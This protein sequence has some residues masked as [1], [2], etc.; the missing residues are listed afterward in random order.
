MLKKK[1]RLRSD[2][3]DGSL[4]YST[5]SAKKESTL[6]RCLEAGEDVI[7]FC[8]VRRFLIRFTLLPP[9]SD[10]ACDLLDSHLSGGKEEKAL[11]G[12]IFCTDETIDYV[13]P[14]AIR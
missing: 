4:F 7:D 13:E 10:I 14:L 1:N 8:H 12:Q 5:T 3:C 2:V 9:S 6:A 11:P